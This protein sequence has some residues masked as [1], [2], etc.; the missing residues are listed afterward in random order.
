M[1]LKVHFK[2]QTA[3][4]PKLF[5]QVSL[6]LKM[7]ESGPNTSFHILLKLESI[8]KSALKRNCELH[9]IPKCDKL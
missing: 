1:A 3:C 8:N 5:Y 6:F 7:I 9:F 4:N 2:V